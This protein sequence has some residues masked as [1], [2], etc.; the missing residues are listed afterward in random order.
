MNNISVEPINNNVVVEVSAPKDS[1]SVSFYPTENPQ[2]YSE[3]AKKYCDDAAYFSNNAVAI[4]K[5]TVDNIENGL[6][7]SINV[8]AADLTNIDAV[9]S[10]KTNI[11]A[12]VTNLSE[13]NSIFANLSNINAVNLNKT[14][15]DTLADNMTKVNTVLNNITSI[16]TIVDN[17]SVIDGFTAEFD[18]IDQA[19]GKESGSVS[20]NSDILSDAKK[21]AHSTFDL[22]K[23]TVVGSPII[24][25]DG[26][27]SGFSTSKY[28]KVPKEI[29]NSVGTKSWKI[30]AV[31]TFNANT[32]SG[33]MPA[34]LG[35]NY[36]VTSQFFNVGRFVSGELKWVNYVTL[37]VSGTKTSTFITQPA[38]SNDYANKT[39]EYTLEYN[40]VTKAY[41]VKM[42]FDDVVV[43][44]NSITSNY[45]LAQQDSDLLVGYNYGNSSIDLKQFSIT[46]DGVPVFSGNKTGIDT[47]KADDYTV[48][49]TPVITADGIASG[50]NDSSYISTPTINFSTAN[51]WSLITKFNTGTSWRS[52]EEGILSGN[53]TQNIQVIINNSGVLR[54]AFGNGT[55][56]F[57]TPNPIAQLSLNT[58]YI[59]ELGYNGTAYYVKLDGV[60]INS[61]TSNDKIPNIAIR[62]GR[63]R[64]N[65]VYFT[66]GTFDLN[67]FKIYVNGNLVYQPCLKIPYTESKTGSKIVDSYYRDRI[68]DMYNQ[69]GYAPYYTLSD[70]D[71][72]LPMGEIYG[73]LGSKTLR[74]S[75]RNGADYWEIYSDNTIE[76][77][78]ICTSGTE[79]VLLKSY[80]DTN[81]ILTIPYTAKT[82]TTF[83]PSQSG[84]WIAKG[85]Y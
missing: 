20:T 2:I 69:F 35:Q 31:G 33:Y 74:T 32:S 77:G 45:Y 60:L 66:Y 13:I 30:K 50:F 40:S 83:T 79:V 9:N 21:Y 85:T 12:V 42:S 41:S 43:I 52:Q 29:L 26:I 18:R 58:N 59:L 14:N 5:D 64:T 51:T 72:T 8:V 10:N 70:T 16:N 25:D 3:L 80:K 75:Y 44:N 34:F 49:G 22:S 15:I 68:T 78:G 61:Y 7:N 23:F 55:A 11:N 46:V 81:Y 28:I 63:D 53:L 67:A 24:T 82:A 71:F 38:I 76:Q 47:V 73:M 1:V 56:W 36:N 39:F 27:A 17:I 37:D 84:N 54:G 4:I 19:K 65:S 48:V 6:V 62:L 57:W